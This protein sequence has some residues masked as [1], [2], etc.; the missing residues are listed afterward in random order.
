MKNNLSIFT[1]F[2][3]LGL[4]FSCTAQ[5]KDKKHIS[6]EDVRN[7]GLKIEIVDSAFTKLLSVRE[8]AIKSNLLKDKNSYVDA[9]LICGTKIINTSIRFK[10]DHVDH[11]NG[12][13]WSFRVKTKQKGFVFGEDKFSIQ[14]VHT[15][16]FLN[17]WIFH[18]LLEKEG[19]VYLQYYFIPFQ[20]NNIDSLKGIYA[21][22]SHFKT[23]LLKVQNKKPGPIAKFEEK[24]LW[25]YKYRSGEANRDSMIMTESEIK[26]TAKKGYNKELGN[27]LIKNIDDYRTGEVTANEVLDIGKWAKF[28]AVNGIMKSNHALRWHNLRFYL[29]PETKLIEPVGFDCISWHLQKGAWF[30]QEAKQEAFYRGLFHSQEFTTALHLEATKMAEKDYFKDFFNDNEVEMDK[31]IK[32]IQLEVP[33]YKFWPISFYKNQ[34]EVRDYLKSNK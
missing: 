27:I 16:A 8:K 24:L 12:N 10:G 6:L 4:L 20:I 11:L 22:E 13:R 26:L 3:V 34:N 29:N 33:D 1:V 7:N 17:E 31:N 14:G 18:K 15:R 32:L 21:F 30:L 23:N 25:D 5:V 19:L 28:I 2:T 9:K